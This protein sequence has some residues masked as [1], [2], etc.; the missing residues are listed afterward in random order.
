MLESATLARDSG[1]DVPPNAPVGRSARVARDTVETV[2]NFIVKE[3]VSE[4]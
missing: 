2:V 4:E 1:R 3:R